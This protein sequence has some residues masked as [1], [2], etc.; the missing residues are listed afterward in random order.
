MSSSSKR[1]TME[2]GVISHKV[3]SEADLEMAELNL[4]GPQC[5]SAEKLN[6]AALPSSLPLFSSFS[7]TSFLPFLPTPSL[8]H[9]SSSFVF[10]SS[11]YSLFVM[12]FYYVASPGWLQVQGNSSALATWDYRL[13]LPHP[14]D[15]YFL[16][17]CFY[18]LD[19]PQTQDDILGLG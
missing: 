19:L 15:Y 1:H 3:N 8:P 5:C 17:K 14:G 2:M 12:R 7:H 16:I 6:R 13:L 4:I 9:S 11:F 10:L 18:L